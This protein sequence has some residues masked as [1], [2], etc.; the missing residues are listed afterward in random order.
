MKE[1]FLLAFVSLDFWCTG[2]W[3]RLAI[4]HA[5][6]VSF[7]SFRLTAISPKY[8]LMEPSSFAIWNMKKVI[9]AFS[10]GVWVANISLMLEC[11][12]HPFIL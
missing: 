12:F 7:L 8:V 2:P 9:V 1:R 10:A 4:D 3:L 11:E 5:S 6:H